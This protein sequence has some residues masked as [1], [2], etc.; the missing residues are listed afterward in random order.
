[1]IFAEDEQVELIEG[2]IFEQV[3]ASAAG[4]SRQEVEDN[5]VAGS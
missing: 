1:M 2:E 3:A 4:R 5:F